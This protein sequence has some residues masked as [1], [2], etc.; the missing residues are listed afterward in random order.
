MNKQADRIEHRSEMLVALLRSG[1]ESLALQ[2][3]M[4][5]RSLLDMLCRDLT[6][7]QFSPMEKAKLDL[8]R[9]LAA[10]GVAK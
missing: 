1:N 4:D 5:L 7:A 2:P 3:A 10:K 9:V 8:A 6:M